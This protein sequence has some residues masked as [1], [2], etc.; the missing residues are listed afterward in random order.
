MKN[1]T[2]TYKPVPTIKVT[3]LVLMAMA[4]LFPLLFYY[5]NDG[6]TVTMLMRE[7]CLTPL[8]LAGIGVIVFAI[9]HVSNITIARTSISNLRYLL[10]LPVIIFFVYWWLFVFLECLEKSWVYDATFTLDVWAYRQS[11]GLYMAATVLIYVFESGLNFYKLAQVK[12]AEVEQLQ[13]EYAQTRLQVLKNQVN[14][15]FLFNSLSVLSSLVQVS[16]ETSDLFIQQ[17]SKAYRYILDQREVDWVSLKVELEFLDAYFFLLQ[18]RFD[19]KIKLEK[20]IDLDP[21]EYTVP[22]YSL[23]LLLENAVKHNRMS[24]SEP[25]VIRLYTEGEALVMANN[26]NKRDQREHS[27]GVGLENIRSR[28]SFITERTIEISNNGTEFMVR[29]PLLKHT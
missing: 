20:V 28:Y 17:L 29:I 12:T 6:M 21:A 19:K 14:P 24:N 3:S 11:I 7:L 26:I 9:I 8:K 18:I 1:K 13:K 16:A 5:I 23:Q 4:L 25:L 27:T 10:E 22:P 2:S 15:H